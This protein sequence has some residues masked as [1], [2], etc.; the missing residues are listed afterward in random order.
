MMVLVDNNPR[1]VIALFAQMKNRALTMPDPHL[2][3]VATLTG[4]AWLAVG[5]GYSIAMD[6]GPARAVGHAERLKR[7]GDTVGEP[8]EVSS[9]QREDFAAH[10]G[11]CLGEDVLQAN[12]QPSSRT[13]RGHQTPAAF[14]MLASGLAA[15]GTRSAQPLKYTHLDIAGSAGDVPLPPTGAP[16]LA[17]VKAH[18]E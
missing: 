13:P 3:T 18:L 9:I 4:H 16:I 12:N 8:F 7:I 2:F 1:D 14:M 11:Q 10:Q 17:L 5:V 6:N 15:H